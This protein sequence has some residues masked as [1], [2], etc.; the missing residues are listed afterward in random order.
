MIVNFTR[1]ADIPLPMKVSPGADDAATIQAALNAGRLVE[2]EPNAVFSSASPVEISLN[3]G[4]QLVGNGATLDG[5]NLNIIEKSDV[6]ISNL[7]ITGPTHANN[8]SKIFIKNSHDIKLNRIVSYSVPALTPGQRIFMVKSQDGSCYNIDIDSCESINDGC[9]GITIGG[10]PGF[11]GTAHNISIRNCRCINNGR[12]TRSDIYVCGINVTDQVDTVS[13]I[14]VDN[15]YVEGSYLC[16]YYSDD[17][18]AKKNI[19]FRNCVA[20]DCGQ[21]G[22]SYGFLIHPGMAMQNCR[23][24][25]NFINLRMRKIP[26]DVGSLL[27]DG[28]QG[29]NSVS[30]DINLNDAGGDART[31]LSNS[32]SFNAGRCGILADSPGN[33]AKNVFVKNLNIHEPAGWP[34]T[35]IDNYFSVGMTDSEIEINCFGGSQPI[36]VYFKNLSNVSYK[37]NVR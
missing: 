4:N 14:S 8:I 9:H 6:E 17:V 20:K 2:L 37:V 16:G 7:R 24:E 29:Q 35:Q 26:A 22:I 23:A 5:I 1:E 32:H 3:S 13:D 25:H 30:D 10:E 21:D 34:A 11:A 28:Y 15:C 33:A 12:A 18:G 31:F 27:V 36:P 19:V